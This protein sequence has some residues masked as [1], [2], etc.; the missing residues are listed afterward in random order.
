MIMISNHEIGLI[1]RQIGYFNF[2]WTLFSIYRSIFFFVCECHG[3]K[4]SYA[5]LSRVKSCSDG[6][7]RITKPP[8]LERM[9]TQK[10]FKVFIEQ[11]KGINFASRAVASS[12][13][14]FIKDEV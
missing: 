10:Y 8:T 9:H 7:M 1:V 5:L 3:I 11:R 4:N 6:N 12:F 14:H 2:G 13:L